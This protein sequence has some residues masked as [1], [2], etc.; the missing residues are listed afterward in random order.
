MGYYAVVLDEH[1]LVPKH[2]NEASNLALLNEEGRLEK[3]ISLEGIKEAKQPGV[4]LYDLIM[5]ET[6]ISELY[7]G[8]KLRIYTIWPFRK[9][10]KGIKNIAVP[11]KPL[12]DIA[13]SIL[14]KY[15]SIL[16]DA[17]YQPAH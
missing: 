14:N 8:R 3:T 11:D 9:S 7:T 6:D 5:K 10:L 15:H 13:E 16:Q 12:D 2:L 1:N 4:Y 17:A